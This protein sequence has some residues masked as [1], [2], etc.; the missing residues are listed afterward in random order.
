MSKKIFVFFCLIVFG[1]IVY[2]QNT[3]S[4]KITAEGQISTSDIHIHIGQKISSCNA[5][6]NY[7]VNNLPNGVTKIF[8]SHIGYQSIDTVID[9]K[10]NLK[11]DFKLKL[12]TTNLNEVII[13]QKTN[14]NYKSVAEQQIKL[15]TIEKYSN[16]TNRVFY[17]EV[18]RI[19]WLRIGI[20][21]DLSYII[22]EI[23][24]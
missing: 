5:S 22:K 12:N 20:N 7:S 24:I 3:I 1:N 15:E 2:S 19:S 17:R 13:H 4:G 8:I 21:V 16:Q 11:I 14:S 6:G 18:P 9:L 10:S 23:E